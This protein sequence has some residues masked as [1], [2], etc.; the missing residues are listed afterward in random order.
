MSLPKTPKIQKKL[1]IL[2]IDFTDEEMARARD[3]LFFALSCVSNY[4]FLI[5]NRRF[6]AISKEEFMKILSEAL[7]KFKEAAREAPKTPGS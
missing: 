5:V 6:E 2:Y 1:L 3:D 4:Q 7:N